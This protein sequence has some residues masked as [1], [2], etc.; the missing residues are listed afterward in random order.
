MIEH[1]EVLRK[2]T[3]PNNSE[4]RYKK[5]MY[6]PDRGCVRTLRTLYVYATGTNSRTCSP[7]YEYVYV[8]NVT[9]EM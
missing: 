1:E 9:C 4:I 6:F 7:D 3:D 2:L 8:M 5:C